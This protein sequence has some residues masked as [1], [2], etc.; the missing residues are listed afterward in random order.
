M[1]DSQYAPQR[2]PLAEALAVPD[3]GGV[4]VPSPPPDVAST[5][6]PADRSREVRIVL[7][8]RIHQREKQGRHGITQSA[9]AGDT[10]APRRMTYIATSS[11]NVSARFTPHLRACSGTRP[12]TWGSA[13]LL[14]ATS[15]GRRGGSAP[16]GDGTGDRTRNCHAAQ[17][18]FRDA[19][20][21]CTPLG[22]R[23][24]PSFPHPVP[25][26]A[27]DDATHDG[28]AEGAEGSES[29]VHGVTCKFGREHRP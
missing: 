13:H 2:A 16:T 23:N 27:V 25:D 20:R 10:A 4:R 7:Q 29:G 12:S 22:V 5:R 28:E 24:C 19:E 21:R 26:D 9:R 15:R 17:R 11:Q 1:P 8:R 6:H 3:D 18:P 14:D